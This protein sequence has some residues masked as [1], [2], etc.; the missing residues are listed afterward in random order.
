MPLYFSGTVK[1]ASRISNNVLKTSV[2]VG[3][4]ICLYTTERLFNDQPL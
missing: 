3:E 1:F 4:S 2:T